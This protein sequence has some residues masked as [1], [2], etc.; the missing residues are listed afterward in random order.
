MLRA[1]PRAQPPVVQGRPFIAEFR[2]R[3]R[4]SNHGG[5]VGRMFRDNKGRMRVDY[6]DGNEEIRIIDDAT[7]STLMLLDMNR[8]LMQID[9]Y[10][11]SAVGWSFRMAVPTY[12]NDRA[13]VKGVECVRVAFRP[14]QQGAADTGDLGETWIAESEGVV[15]KDENVGEEWVWEVTAIEFREPEPSTF[16]VPADFVKVED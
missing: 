1:L 3:T 11:A 2:C 6:M 14:P 10:Q 13:M 12:T 16:D 7:A 9:T 15:M 4:T 8:R 5:I